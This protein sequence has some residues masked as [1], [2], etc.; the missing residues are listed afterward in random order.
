MNM[1]L[2]VLSSFTL[3]VYIFKQYMNRL[4]TCEAECPFKTQEIRALAA[5]T[6]ATTIFW[7]QTSTIMIFLTKW[8]SRQC[9]LFG[10]NNFL[11]FYQW[12]SIGP[13]TKSPRRAT[14]IP[15]MLQEGPEEFSYAKQTAPSYCRGLEGSMSSYFGS[16]VIFSEFRFMCK[17]VEWKWKSRWQ[18]ACISLWRK[19]IVVKSRGLP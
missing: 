3:V 15:T 16:Q 9:I 17:M 18:Q 7:K 1:T 13:M 2:F 4:Y 12:H 5:Q 10:L 6:E 8:G 19:E 11:W 14:V